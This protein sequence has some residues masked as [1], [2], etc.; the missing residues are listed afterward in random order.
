M[1]PIAILNQTV[2]IV[3][4]QSTGTDSLG[5]PIYG[6]PT[7]GAGWSTIYTGLQVRLAFSSKMTNFSKEGERVNP[8]GVVYLNPGPEIYHEDRVVFTN[9]QNGTIEYN[10]INVIKALG[11]SGQIDHLELTVQ[12]P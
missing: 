4:R 12:L 5:N 1:L 8:T 7:S 3:R 6:Q 10:V 9:Y 2:N 11:V